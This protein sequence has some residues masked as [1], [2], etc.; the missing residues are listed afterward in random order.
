[1]C[2][3]I[4]FSTQNSKQMS[5]TSMTVFSNLYT[6]NPL[7]DL[8]ENTSKLTAVK[9]RKSQN[10]ERLQR[11]KKYNIRAFAFH[12]QVYTAT[13]MGCTAHT[14]RAQEGFWKD[15]P[16]FKSDITTY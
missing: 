5:T 1:M 10:S 14:S 2:C 7:L 9:S 12:F 15:G 8:R 4:N 16:G 6:S 11:E 13:Y 3:V